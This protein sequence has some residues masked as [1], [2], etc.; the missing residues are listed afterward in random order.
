LLEPCYRV[1][2]IAIG[3]W[4]NLQKTAQRV[5]P[6]PFTRIARDPVSNF[7]SRKITARDHRI[8]IFSK[9]ESQLSER[10]ADAV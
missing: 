9:M 6:T 10:D 8:A 3:P 4:P 7:L 1:S 2:G 5:T